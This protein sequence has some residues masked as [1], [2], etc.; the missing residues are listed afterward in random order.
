M[1]HDN[2]NDKKII[3]FNK[4]FYSTSILKFKGTLQY[5]QNLK[6]V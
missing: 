1:T 6:S 3:I 4:D 2:D 5:R